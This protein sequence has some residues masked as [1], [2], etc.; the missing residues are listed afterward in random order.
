MQKHMSRIVISRRA[1]MASIL[2]LAAYL[3]IMRG[4]KPVNDTDEMVQSG[5]W[6]LKK[7]DLS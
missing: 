7:S 1:F 6:L 4:S 5:R 3:R 2:S